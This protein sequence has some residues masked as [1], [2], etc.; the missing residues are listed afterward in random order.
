MIHIENIHLYR[1]DKKILN[2]LSWHVQKGQHWAI[3]GLNGSGK[4]TL[5]KVINGYIWPNEGKVQVLGETYGKTYIPKLRTRIGWVSN[6]MIDNFNWQDN[7]IE[8]VLSGKFGALRLFNDVTE[9]EIDHAVS[10]MKHFHCDHLA[11]KSFEHLSQGERQR[12]QIARAIMADPEILILDEPCGGLDL[13][14]RENL[15]QTIEQIAQAENG[16]TLIY[17]TH[18]VEEILPCFSHVLL[19]K[20]GKNVEANAREVVLTDELL[21]DFFGREISLQ[22]ERERAWV[23]IK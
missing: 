6:A 14:E 1:N 7:A 20:D 21:S 11:N 5:L 18:H 3:L 16:P 9:E 19:M 17:V 4:T 8:I 2:D 12:V 10:I 22:I 15:L 23:A 13:I